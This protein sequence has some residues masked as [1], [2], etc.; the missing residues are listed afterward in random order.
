MARTIDRP[1]RAHHHPADG[2]AEQHAHDRHR[3][4]EVELEVALALLPPQLAG[5]HPD[6]VQPE[7]GHRPAQH[8][9]PDVLRGRL[10]ATGRRRRR[11]RSRGTAGGSR[12]AATTSRG[13]GRSRADR[14]GHPPSA[15]R[16]SAA[17]ASSTRRPPA[18]SRCGGTRRP[19]RL[20][21]PRRLPGR[22][23]WT[24]R[25]DVRV[26]TARPGSAGTGG[27]ARRRSSSKP[28]PTSSTKTSSRLGSEFWSERICEPRP[29]SAPTTP[30]SALSSTRTRLIVTVWRSTRPASS[31][32]A[33]AERRR[34]DRPAATGR[35]RVGRAPAGRSIRAGPGA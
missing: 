21:R 2:H 14:R 12:R 11:P 5:H 20:R 1:G 10:R 19:T 3:G 22:R 27:G 13:T 24:C 31:A 32:A 25:R 28:R 35:R 23:S 4:G 6:H 30:P 9:E 8:D 34:A 29:P 16:S 17:G 33:F 18:G 7:R 15:G 26:R